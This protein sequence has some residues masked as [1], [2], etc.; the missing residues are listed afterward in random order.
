[1]KKHPWK[2]HAPAAKGRHG[3]GGDPAFQPAAGSSRSPPRCLIT[4]TDWEMGSEIEVGRGDGY[5]APKYGN[6]LLNE[7]ESNKNYITIIRKKGLPWWLNGKESTCNAGATGSTPGSGRSPGG[8][9]GNPL[10]FSCLEKSHG[11]RSLLGYSPWGRTVRHHWSDLVHMHR[12]SNRSLLHNSAPIPSDQ[13]L[14]G[15]WVIFWSM[16][17][18]LINQKLCQL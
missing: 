13:T 1:M 5:V 9:H 4:N 14:S 8:G 16:A 10:Q 12:V 2:G 18:F 3:Q 7:N 6:R 17:E 11:Q 15:A